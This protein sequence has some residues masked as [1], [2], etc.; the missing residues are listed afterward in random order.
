MLQDRGEWPK[1]ECDVTGE[2]TAMH[3]ENFL[4]SWSKEV[5]ENMKE[6]WRLTGRPKR[7]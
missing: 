6:T 3:E 7:R 5:G 4:S 2:Y 1:E